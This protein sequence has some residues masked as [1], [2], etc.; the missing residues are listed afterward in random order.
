MIH[1]ELKKDLKRA[2]E[3]SLKIKVKEIHL[4]H[5]ENPEFGDYASNF[6]LVK[7][8]EIKSKMPNLTNPLDL[9][10]KI[11]ENFS[12]KDYL[13]KVEVF[14]PGF[15]NFYLK[16]KIFCS[17]LK[18]ILREKEKYGSS[19]IGRKKTIVIDYSAPNIA[20]PFNIGH[21]R[22]TIIGQALYNIYK[23][24][25][26]KVIGD[27]H[28][29]DWG[30]QYGKLIYAIKKWG[31]EKEIEKDPIRKLHE[32]YV[33]FHE[34]VEK[35][36]QLEDEGRK[37]FKKLEKGDRE[38]ERIWKKCVDWSLKEFDR[39]YR[40]LDIKIDLTLG[41][42]FYVPMLKNIIKEALKKRVGSTFW[43]TLPIK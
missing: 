21:L 19:K 43:F 41:E 28:I 20:K 12:K 26:Y 24:L 42:S 31:N 17:N 4:E 1:S 2:I 7:F 6:A 16:D 39:I 27:N 23:F 10:K 3:K 5:P 35:N 36:P 18:K 29:G 9:A 38:A 40:I 34:E 22:S 8:K 30:T 14:P 37:W 32:L 33:R 13:E 25:G 11:I 15:I